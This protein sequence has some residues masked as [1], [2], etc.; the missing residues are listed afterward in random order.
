MPANSESW[1]GR[2]L[3]RKTFEHT[4]VTKVELLQPQILKVFRKEHETVLIGCVAVDRVIPS[5]IESLL[6]QPFTLSFIV[7]IP[8]ESFWT[9]PAIELAESRS[10]GFGGMDDLFRALNGPDVGS[11]RRKEFD[12]FE[13]VVKEHDNIL[14]I[15]RVHDRKYSLTR[16]EH[17]QVQVLLLNEYALC[18]EKVRISRERYG[19]FRVI[20]ITNPNGEATSQAKR[21]ARNL[22]VRILKMRGFLGFLKDG[23]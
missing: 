19:S 16:Y 18:A 21:A 1:T 12:Y 4:N 23:T 17:G 20:L 3:E 14:E 5:Q 22:G 11:Y 2:W 9:G 13:R 8:A 7:N 15:D 10:L 6:E